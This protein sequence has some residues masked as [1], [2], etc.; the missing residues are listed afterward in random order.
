MAHNVVVKGFSGWVGQALA[1]H[2]KARENVEWETGKR[3]VG[4]LGSIQT[5][6]AWRFTSSGLYCPR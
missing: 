1:C 5:Q 4:N 2:A 6:A 3:R